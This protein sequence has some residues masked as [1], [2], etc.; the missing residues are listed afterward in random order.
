MRIRIVIAI[1]ALLLSAVALAQLDALMRGRRP[2][3]F[4]HPQG[5]YALEFPRSWE[6]ELSPQN[7]LV[8]RRTQ[9]DRAELTVTL[10]KVPR[11]VDTEMVALNAGRALKQLPHYVDRGGGRLKVA[12]KA[13][14]MRSFE[15]DY[16]GNTEYTIAVE[17]L[18]VVSGT[19]LFTVH[20]E[21]LKRSFP[22]FGK[23]LRQIYDSFQVAEIDAAGQPIA[24]ARPK[25]VRRGNTIMP[26][27]SLMG[28]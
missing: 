13:A 18:Y 9:R 23:D 8:A 22:R 24:P 3:P 26:D 19:V 6:F 7:Q 20:F 4:V 28:R 11:D 5:F 21:V 15:F 2:P 27:P 14:S 17:E 1:G 16:Q 25:A 10:K 12:G